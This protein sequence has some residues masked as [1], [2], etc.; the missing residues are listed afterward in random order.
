MTD[1]SRQKLLTQRGPGGV[2]RPV[3]HGEASSSQDALQIKQRLALSTIVYGSKAKT[4][5]QSRFMSTT[6]QPFA[7]A[8]SSALSSCPKLDLRS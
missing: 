6:T 7:F 4:R 2:P 1:T 3:C 8:S 5:F